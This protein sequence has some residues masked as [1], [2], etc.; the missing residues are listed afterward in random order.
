MTT[1][2][3]AALAAFSMILVGVPAGADE[4][5]PRG[6]RSP[7]DGVV[8]TPIEVHKAHDQQHGPSTGHIPGSSENVELV[9][10]LTV[11][12]AEEGRIS[13]VWSHGDFA[14][15]GTFTQPD[16]AASGV[17][18]LDI[19]DPTDPQ[20][21]G[22]ISQDGILPGSDNA[23]PQDL[24][25]ISL[26][27][28]AFKG[29]VLI[30]SN[31]QCSFSQQGVGGVSL[32]DVTDPRNPEFLANGGDFDLAGF[33]FGQAN[34]V[35]NVFPWTDG[36]RAYA[37]LV[38]DFELLDV[39]ILDI[40][41]PR[42]PELVAE[43]GLP[44]WPDAVVNGNGGTAFNHDVWVQRV[45]G[46]N[47]LAVSYWDAGFVLL[48]VSDPVD[49]TFIGDSDY[50]D[51]DSLTGLSPAEGNAHAAVFSPS[52][53]FLLAGDEDFSPS[54]IDPFEITTGPDAGEFPAGEFGW[55][56]P[57][58]GDFPSG[59][60]NGPTIYGG[61]ACPGEDLDGNGVDDRDDVPPASVLTPDAGEERVLV[62]TR[63][64]CFFSL[65]VESG[66]LKGY[67][68]VIIGNHH[69]GAAGGDAPDAAIC[70]GQ[71]SPVLGEAAGL[72]LGHR[73]MHLI[74]GDA[75]EFQPVTGVTSPDM[76]PPG[77]LGEEVRAASLF[78]GWGPLR[79]IDTGTLKEVDVFA[80]PQVT[81]PAFAQGFGD[82]T[83]HNVETQGDIAAISWYSLG[84]RV[85]RFGPDGLR[86]VG[87]YI[88]PDGNN[89]WGV[90]FARGHRNVILASDRDTGLW[91]FRFTGPRNP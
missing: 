53:R 32:W 42:N 66:E 49:P 67:D 26:N 3:L 91:I 86:E 33:L 34:G 58:V 40:T 59:E 90:H 74:F 62:V 71:G 13:D 76:P 7:T 75:V 89:L 8:D 11:S 83:M 69:A 16:C 51:P 85:L 68:A 30:H 73:A 2:H 44:D 5:P 21:V 28:P 48:D 43:T 20:E 25:V 46:R 17:Y 79:L 47:T 29:D 61:S 45:R 27:T 60:V 14:Y 1:R 70:G 55:T 54:R 72:C 52:G 18:V 10:Q 15:L 78:D 88:D 19:S 24:K 31:E 4:Q 39:D 63:G 41:D 6:Y 23:R 77:T 36:R 38:D 56:S 80:P 35:H 9:G 84:L 65:K 81:D 64:T 87:H 82:L 12:G 57:R 37:A 50:P 22:F